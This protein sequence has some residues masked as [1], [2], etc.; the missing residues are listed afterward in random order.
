LKA[1]PER[2]GLFFRYCGLGIH[3][4]AFRKDLVKRLT[5]P[6]AKIAVP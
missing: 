4:D 3:Y 5:D 6:Q 2:L 1:C